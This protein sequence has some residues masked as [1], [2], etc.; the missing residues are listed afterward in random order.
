MSLKL[1][2]ELLFSALEVAYSPNRLLTHCKGG[3]HAPVL[4]ENDVSIKILPALN[5][6]SR[7]GIDVL[8]FDNKLTF[9]V[10]T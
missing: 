6:F 2:L 5:V 4:L 1:L 7:S 10:A 3:F 9:L 8:T